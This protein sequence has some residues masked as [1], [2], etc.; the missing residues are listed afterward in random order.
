MLLLLAS[1]A[2]S[3]VAG[4]V[5]VLATLSLL[6]GAKLIEMRELEGVPDSNEI[7]WRAVFVGVVVGSLWPITLKGYSSKD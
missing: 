2:Y 5:S 1:N 6:R 4:G 7:F 3:F